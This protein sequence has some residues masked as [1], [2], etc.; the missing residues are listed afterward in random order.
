MKN[1]EQHKTIKEE[2]EELAPTLAQLKARELPLEAPPA[3]FDQ[4]SDELW[5]KWQVNTPEPTVR[6]QNRWSVWWANLFTWGWKPA[7]SYAL[8]G[9]AV[10]VISLTVLLRQNDLQASIEETALSQED[11]EYYINANLDD[12]DLGLLAEE[13]MPL[14]LEQSRL[15]EEDSLKEPELEQLFDELLDDIALEE[16]L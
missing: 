4:L 1:E 2:L 3:Y 15:P 9:I 5:Q 16:L 6:E 8:A 13:S 14:P 10:V 11:I 12:F 7:Y